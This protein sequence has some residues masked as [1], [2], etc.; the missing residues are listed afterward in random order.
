MSV[1]SG[2]NVSWSGLEYPEVLYHSSYLGSNL[3]GFLWAEMKE[4]PQCVK[5]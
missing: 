1:T 2:H 4:N 5:T 3:I